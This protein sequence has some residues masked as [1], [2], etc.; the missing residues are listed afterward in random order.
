VNA[1]QPDT[2]WTSAA[3]LAF[4]VLLL[5]IALHLALTGRRFQFHGTVQ[6][7][8][9][10][11]P[12][13]FSIEA[14]L[15]VV[16][17]LIF[18][19]VLFVVSHGQTLILRLAFAFAGT[20]VLCTGAWWVF[21]WVS[22]ASEAQTEQNRVWRRR[23]L[24][25]GVRIRARMDPQALRVELCRAVSEY[26]DA[27]MVEVLARDEGP[28]WICR[29]S[30]LQ[31]RTGIAHTYPDIDL[32]S[33]DPFRAHVSRAG[34]GLHLFPIPITPDTV[35]WL[36]VT[37]PYDSPIRPDTRHYLELCALQAGAALHSIDSSRDHSAEQAELFAAEREQ[38]LWRR[39]MGRLV[40][41]D[42]PDIAGL[43]YGAEYW[44]GQAPQGQFIDLIS[45]PQG[46]LGIVLAEVESTGMEAAVQIAQLQVLLRSRFQA[47]AE[48]LAELLQSTER[49][50]LSSSE[51]PSPV[52]LFCGRYAPQSRSLTYVNAGAVAPLMVRR[53]PDGAQVLRL[54]ESSAPMAFDPPTSFRVAELILRPGDLVAVPS[55]SLLFNPS[56]DP[57]EPLSDSRLA[58]ALIDWENRKA[59]DLVRLV[60]RT[61]EE[62]GPAPATD[63]AMILLKAV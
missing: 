21:S 18:G 62:A 49:A 37:L 38:Q 58:D 22:D 2:I 13:A 23:A 40:P 27:S 53:E 43:E 15:A 33:L 44:R 20:T 1:L 32:H 56:A 7:T 9:S 10:G 46:A 48:D 59:S 19:V 3:W 45:L 29:A 11:R 42:L 12:S 54:P 41:P 35:E 39:A 4:S 17:C 14:L 50:L 30:L 5:L 57:R 24:K 26:L 36:A 28:D 8:R 16:A 55:L 31:A 61:I 34:R 52:R 63:R 51:K 60:F 47:Y 25:T 6:H